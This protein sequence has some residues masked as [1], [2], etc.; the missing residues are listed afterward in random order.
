MHIVRVEATQFKA[1]SA[2]Y[3][4]GCCLFTYPVVGPLAILSLHPQGKG[5]ILLAWIAGGR[6]AGGLLWCTF[7]LRQLLQL[8]NYPHTYYLGHPQRNAHPHLEDSG[9]VRG[10]A[11]CNQF[12]QSLNT[13]DNNLQNQTFIR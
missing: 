1:A 2:P 13:Q 8:T 3:L 11:T 4:H 5:S 6:A 9:V 10:H 7:S 12:L